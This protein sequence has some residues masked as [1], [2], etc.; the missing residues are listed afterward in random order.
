MITPHRILIAD[1]ESLIRWS[2]G[3]ALSQKGYEVFSVEN[4][5]KA[6]EA[7]ERENFDFIITDLMMP[8]LDGW[9]VLE[10]AQRTWPQPRVIIMT[11]HGKES[12]KMAHERGAWG[13]VEKPYLVEK[14]QELLNLP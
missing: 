12:K 4:G 13:Y 2:L 6:V 10:A 11:A 3:Q 9:K 8:D 7:I 5:R 1:D 14:I